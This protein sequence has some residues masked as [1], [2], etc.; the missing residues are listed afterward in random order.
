MSLTEYIVEKMVM[1][2]KEFYIALTRQDLLNLCSASSE[3]SVDN[4]AHDILKR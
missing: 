4:V 1:L 2:Q 3:I